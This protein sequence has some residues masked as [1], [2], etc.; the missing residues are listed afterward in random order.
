MK[1]LD[2]I[3]ILL[4]ILLLILIVNSYR[5]TTKKYPI[6]ETFV[7]KTNQSLSTKAFDKCYVI[8]L[9][10]TREGRRRWQVF[11]KHPILAKYLVRYPGIYGATYNYQN[12]INRGIIKSKWDFGAWQGLNTNIIKMDRSLTFT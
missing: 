1:I 4:V 10:E 12:E 5:P 8:N 7:S 11:Q 2:K 6:R 3:I 9:Q